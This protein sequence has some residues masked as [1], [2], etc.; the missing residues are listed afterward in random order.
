LCPVLSRQSQFD[1]CQHLVDKKC[2]ATPGDFII[3]KIQDISPRIPKWYFTFKITTFDGAKKPLSCVT[4]NTE[5]KDPSRV[6][7][8]NLIDAN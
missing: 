8:E 1:F 6:L 4:L 2:P 3:H 5:V 7:D